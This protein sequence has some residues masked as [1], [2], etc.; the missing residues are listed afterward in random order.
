MT[1]VAAPALLQETAHPRLR[2]VMGTMYYGFYYVGSLLSS[3]LCGTF[4]TRPELAIRPS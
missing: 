1:K 4:P 2:S 3:I